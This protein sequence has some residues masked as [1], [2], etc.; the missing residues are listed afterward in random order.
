MYKKSITA[1]KS[2]ISIKPAASPSILDSDLQHIGVNV[3]Y[4]KSINMLKSEMS[5]LSSGSQ[6]TLPV[7]PRQGTEILAQSA[8]QGEQSTGGGPPKNKYVCMTRMSTVSIL[9]SPLKSP[10]ANSHGGGPLWN[11]Y[12]MRLVR[13]TLSM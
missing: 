3:M 6:S 13:S 2:E 9:Q 5:T 1:D 10:L 12:F 7:N 11:T 4:K 8:M